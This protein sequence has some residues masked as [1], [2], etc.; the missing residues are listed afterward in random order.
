MDE[1]R[2]LA[3]IAMVESASG[4]NNLPRLEASFLPRG[5]N[6]TMQGRYIQGTGRWVDDR[7]MA[8]FEKYGPATA[9]SFGPWQLMY[10]TALTL[11]YDGPPWMLWDPDVSEPYARKL[12]RRIIAS[13]ADTPEKVADAW[14]SGTWKDG[15]RPSAYIRKF[16]AAW[17]KL[18]D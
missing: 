15:Y 18:G 11:G 3:T 2:L 1:E 5:Q 4:R 10:A 8:K 13:G 7:L 14:N 6:L 9:C 17:E 16:M 12:L